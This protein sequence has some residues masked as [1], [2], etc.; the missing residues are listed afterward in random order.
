MRFSVPFLDLN[1]QHNLI[2]KELQLAIA[3]VIESGRFISGSEVKR[4]EK[5]VASLC[6]TKYAIG[7]ASGTTGLFLTLRGLGIGF[8]DEV[9]TTPYTF[10]ATVEAISLAGAVPV[11][12]DIDEESFNISPEAIIKF[13]ASCLL[14]AKTK[15]P[16]NP[17]TR[18]LV[19]AIIPVHLFGQCAAME[20]IVQIAQKYNLLIIEDAA[21]SFGSAQLIHRQWQ[22][23]GSI[24]IAGV[25]SFYPTKNL[26]ALGS[27]GMIVTSDEKLAC[28][29][30]ILRD[31]GQYAENYH[32]EIGTNSRLDEIQAA[33][34]LLKMR[35][36]KKWNQARKRIWERY[37][38]LLN[39]CNQVKTPKIMANNQSVF[40]QYVIRTKNRNRLREYLAKNRIE[41]KIYYPLAIHQQKCYKFLGYKAGDLPVAERAA[42]QALALPIYPGLSLTKVEF[43]SK[44]IIDF[45]IT[46]NA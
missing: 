39:H 36:L 12:V 4:L 44:K 34:L 31:H 10:F 14:K 7:V 28:R 41:T 17:K 3:K 38:R 2:K 26:G 45:F 6:G 42:K 43:I 21:Q 13:L 16:I 24:G 40:N 30:K 19:K 9:I 15:Y 5:K 35:Y 1:W 37:S 29:L 33:V 18:A 32:K 46:L 20:P 27:A 11:L 8:G 23:A 25:F 22:K